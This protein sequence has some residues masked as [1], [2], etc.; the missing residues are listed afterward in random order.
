MAAWLRKYIGLII[1]RKTV[2]RHMREMYIQAISPQ[3]NTSK[4][5]S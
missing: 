3:Y 5:E 4:S 2:L 1:N